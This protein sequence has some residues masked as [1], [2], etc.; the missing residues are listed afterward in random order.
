MLQNIISPNFIQFGWKP[1]FTINN[2]ICEKILSLSKYSCYFYKKTYKFCKWHVKIRIK[3]TNHLY[4]SM[5][6]NSPIYMYIYFQFVVCPLIM[7][8]VELLLKNMSSKM[9]CAHLKLKNN[10]ITT[11]WCKITL[12]LALETQIITISKYQICLICIV[13]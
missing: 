7:L 10:L 4:F 1:P 12:F 8:L 2:K 13:S 5:I 11:V 6:C 3:V 9:L